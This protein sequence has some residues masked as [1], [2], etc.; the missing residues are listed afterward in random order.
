[1]IKN[2]I[3]IQNELK[4]PKSNYNSFGKYNYRS[5]ED[6]MTAVKPLLIKYELQL[7]ISDDIIAVGDRI[8]V[9]ATATLVDSDGNMQSATA[10]ARESMAKKGM[11]ES[12]VTGTASSYARKYALNGLFLIDDTKD[13]DTEAYHKQ[14]TSTPQPL[15][16]NETSEPVFD[17]EFI[18][19]H[20]GERITEREIERLTK[21]CAENTRGMTLEKALAAAK[22][23]SVSSLTFIQYLALMS[24]LG[25]AA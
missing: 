19:A 2:L 13:A 10:F 5:A 1:M 21:A 3:L 8:Y 12:Q 15:Q 6:I 23:K 14:T 25:A 11:D 4:A 16:K 24:Q 20:G 18:S 22:R 17:K 7:T 9:K